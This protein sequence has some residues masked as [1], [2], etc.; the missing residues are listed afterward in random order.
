VHL[1]QIDIIGFKSFGEK[2][3]LQF[4]PGM[5]SIVGPNGCGKSNVSDAIRWV[6]GEQR[7]TSLRC[8]RMTDLVFNG[9]DTRKPLGM[10]E[11]A[12]TFAD[13]EGLLDTEFNEV[14]IARR[15]F[16]SGDGQ[17]FINK[18]PCRLKDIHRLFMGTG[19]GTTSYSVMAQGQIDAILSSRPEDRRAVFEEAAGITKFKADRKEA[20]RK[21]E[22]TDINLTRLS[23]VIREVKRQISTLQRQAGKAQ[24]YKALRDQLR[25]FDIFLTRRRLADLDVRIRELDRSIQELSEKIAVY[26]DFV[27]ESEEESTRIHHVISATEEQ[28]ADLTEKATRADNSYLRAQEVIRVNHQRIEEYKAWAERDTLEISGTQRQIDGLTMQMESLEQ[29]RIL[30]QNASAGERE[31]LTAA[32]QAFSGHERLINETRDTLQIIRQQSVECERS[33]AQTQNQLSELESR[34]RELFMKRERLT[35]EQRQVGENLKTFEKNS[36]TIKA[37]LDQFV[38]ERDTVRE[39]LE[40]LEEEREISAAELKSLHSVVARLQS[41]AAARQAQ[42][43]LLNDKKESAGDYPAGSLKLLDPEN[44]LGID[45]SVILGPLAEKFN[46]PK[47][48]RLALEASLRAWLDA[49]IIR[50]GA[51][52]R[53]IL[54]RLQAEGKQAAARIIVAES[55]STVEPLAVPPGL[56]ALLTHITVEKGFQP[57]AE[58]LLGAI[59]LA[60]SADAVPTVIPAG[61]SVVTRAGTIFHSNGTMEL[62]MPESQLSSPLARRMLLADTTEQLARVQADLAAQ[63][64]R[65]E[66]LN[67]RTGELS[68]QIIGIRSELTEI[69]RK[70]AQADGE[71]QSACRDVARARARFET[72]NQEVEGILSVTSGDDENREELLE[73]LHALLEKRTVLLEQTTEKSGSLNQLESVFSTLSHNLTECRITLSSST[74][75]LEHTISQQKN[76]ENHMEELNRTISG[77]SQGVKSYEESIGRLNIEIRNLETNLEPMKVEAETLH[78]K[79][80][81]TRGERTMHQRALEKNE[82]TLAERRRALDSTRE[83]RNKAE[84]G[85]TEARMHH[86]NHL[87]HVYNEYGVSSEELITH[88]DPLW[89]NGEQPPLPEIAARVARLNSEIHEIGPVNLVAIEEHKEYE[90]RYAFLK[91]QEEDLLKSKEQILDLIATINSKSSELFQQTFQQANLNFQEMFTKLFNGG[92]AKLVLLENREDPL[93]CGID[94]IA[95]PPGKRPQ[96]VTLLSGGERT[97]TAVSLLFAIF[98]IKPSPFCLLD[99][100]D[101]A[102]DDSNIGRFVLAL[103]DF[104]AHSQFLIITHNQHTIA[105]SDLVYGVTQQ[106]KGIS[107][108]ISMRLNEIGNKDL[109]V[110]PDAPTIA[111]E[112]NLPAPPKKR[113]KKAKKEEPAEGAAVGDDTEEPAAEGE[114]ESFDETEPT[115][116]VEEIEKL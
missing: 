37:A 109:N 45:T 82:A 92:E 97:M 81:E 87:D 67:A 86:Q 48:M 108:I 104:L 112:A 84:V 6:L 102:L 60:D 100:L 20:L 23:D 46:A 56:T 1:K 59:F 61:T 113:S 91:A 9:T 74:Q 31:Q 115:V 5:I 98:K 34:Q 110:T 41:E 55:A 63:R 14:T 25:S 94:I 24:K 70:A 107:K 58:R 95:R 42:I 73:R 11:V 8:A 51:A 47:E 76:I 18:N 88:P 3:R 40:L 16:R 96:S 57:A 72:V 50:D 71:Y 19:I 12:I 54:A 22:H 68:L 62:W 28:I 101:A 69:S 105:A 49:I 43:D 114:E 85:I 78:A 53:T 33:T 44:P 2:T 35:S 80:T 64:D 75:Q 4:E 13:C 111:V 10:A 106:E 26:A 52:A 103:K 30:M 99:E 17:Y 89:E 90:E 21:I 7:P 77:R 29:K 83:S 65:Q 93:E 39:R 32:Q 116:E 27:S 36:L 15:I 38:E 66:Q 79:I